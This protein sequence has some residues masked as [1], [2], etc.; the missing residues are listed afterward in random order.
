[1]SPV[2]HTG[3]QCHGV[4]AICCHCVNCKAV[5]SLSIRQRWPNVGHKPSR[6]LGQFLHFSTARCALLLAMCCLCLAVIATYIRQ[7]WPNVGHTNKPSRYKVQF[8]RGKLCSKLSWRARGRHGIWHKLYTNNIFL[9][10]FI[11]LSPL[12]QTFLAAQSSSR[13]LVVCWSRG[14]LVGRS[15]HVYKKGWSWAI[16]GDLGQSWEILGN[17]GRSLGILGN[18]GQSWAILSDLW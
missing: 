6:H 8:T 18:L 7:R 14:W 10:N 11:P 3:R 13:S 12:P 2:S 16:L 15:V 5:I 4:P 17:R 9:M 1:M